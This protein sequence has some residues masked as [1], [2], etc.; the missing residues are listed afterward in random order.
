MRRVRQRDTSPEMAV[1]KALWAEGL[2]YRLHRKIEGIR[3]DIVFV[4]AK[5]AVFIDGCFWHGCPIHYVK[6]RTKSHYWD[7]KLLDN[8]E[9]DRRQT[10]LLEDAGWR[11]LRLWE[12]Q[13]K[14]DLDQV[15]RSVRKALRAPDWRPDADWRVYRVSD[16]GSDRPGWQ[17]RY[18][19]RLRDASEIVIVDGPR[20]SG[21]RKW[22]TRAS[23]RHS[24]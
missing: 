12:H 24:D 13:V 22:S 7:P 18:M 3:P 15:V 14:T 1:R 23:R 5:V 17:A 10:M 21:R 4:G 8:V 11:V 9:R 6:P 2:R 19:C 20:V 16:S